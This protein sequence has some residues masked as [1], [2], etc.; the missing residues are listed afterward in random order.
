MLASP[1]L[2]CFLDTYSLSTSSLGCHALCM[3]ISFLVLWSICFSSSRVHL[4]KGPEYLTS[5]TAQVFILLMRFLLESFVSSSFRVL[6][7]YSFRIMSFICTCLMVSASTVLSGDL[8]FRILSDSKSPHVSRT[9][10]STVADL[11]SVIWMVSI[12]FLIFNSSSLFSKC[13]N[14]NW[15]HRHPHVLQFLQFS[16]G[17]QVFYFFRFL[18]FSF[19]G[20][21]LRQ[22]SLNDKFF[23]LLN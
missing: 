12:L 11:K 20:P 22:N 18:S 23:F 19:C 21:P 15:Y 1:L 3:V 13:T 10:L 14:Y 7:R 6:L 4:R 9:L 8:F 16:V 2:P 17:V 5:G